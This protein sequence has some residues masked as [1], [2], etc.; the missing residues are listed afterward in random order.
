M[1]DLQLSLDDALER[2]TRNAH[3]DWLVKAQEAALKL[4]AT[5]GAD[6]FIAD[7]IWSMIDHPGEPETHERRALGGV[8]TALAKQGRIHNTGRTRRSTRRRCRVTVWTSRPFT[9][10]ET[11]Q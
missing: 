4:A 7:D 8:I 3:N 9:S 6:G 2:V 5:R 11:H 10:T 1:T